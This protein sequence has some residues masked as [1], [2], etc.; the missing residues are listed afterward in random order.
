VTTPATIEKRW[1]L[2]AEKLARAIARRYPVG[3]HVRVKWG[4]GAMYGVVKFPPHDYG[5]YPDLIGIQSY[6]GRVHWKRYTEI[7]DVRR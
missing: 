7:L 6:A 2:L 3:T 1:K 4:T 5:R